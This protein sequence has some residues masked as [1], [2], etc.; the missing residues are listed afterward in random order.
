MFDRQKMVLI[1]LEQIWLMSKSRFCVRHSA[2]NMQ[3]Q[4]K[5][6]LNAMYLWNAANCSNQTEFDQQMTKFHKSYPKA[7]DYITKISLHHGA[8]HVFDPLVKAEHTTK[9]ITKCFSVWV[10]KYRA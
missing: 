6:S 10:Q 1:V 3:K 9:N 7:H 4:C 2:T 5:G 8:L